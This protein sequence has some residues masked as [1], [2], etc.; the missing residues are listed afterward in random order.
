MEML[1]DLQEYVQLTIDKG[2]T[3]LEEVHK[4]IANMPLD[5]LE[6]IGPIKGTVEGVK[7]IQANTIGNVYESIRLVNEKAGEIASRLLGAKQ[8]KE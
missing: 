8:G 6:K 7:E 3:S 2:A 4:S 1:K 5:F